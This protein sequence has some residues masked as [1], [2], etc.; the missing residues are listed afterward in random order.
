MTEIATP[1]QAAL[2]ERASQAT[3]IEQ[4]RAVAE[5]AGQ[6]RAALEFP[7]DKVS[8]WDEMREACGFLA[9]AERAFYRVPNRGTG[10]SVHL[11]RELARC[12][13]NVQHGVV[14]LRRDDEA[15]VSEVQAFAW[16]LERNTR[17]VRHFVVPHQRMAKGKRQAL[18]DLADITNNNNSVGARAV[19]EVIWH[20]LPTGFRLEAE[21]LCRETVERGN[22]EPLDKRI[23]A[24]VAAFG[25]AGISEA[26]LVAKVAKQREAWNETD[27]GD[28]SVLFAALRSGEVS[29]AEEFPEGQADANA[30]LAATGGAE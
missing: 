12:W 18:L 10:P 6:I 4:A 20:V 28:L 27:I 29:K 17:S 24:C 9:L 16:D 13:G 19:R 3:A 5:V 26:Q 15:G 1:Q 14:E 2:A 25:A 30:A 7:R 8:A 21:R 23:A 11:A 22:G